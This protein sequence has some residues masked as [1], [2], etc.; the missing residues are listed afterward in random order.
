MIKI[1]IMKK[2]LLLI[3]IMM[4]LSFNLTDA[5]PPSSPMKLDLSFSNA[6]EL[7]ET[8]EITGKITYAGEIPMNINTLINIT[9]PDGFELISGRLIFEEELKPETT[10]KIAVKAVKTGDFTIE[11]IAR[12]PSKGLEYMGGRNFIYISVG[13][14]WSNIKNKPFL[15]PAPPCEEVYIDGEISHCTT[16]EPPNNSIF[17]N[18]PYIFAVLVLLL[19]LLIILLIFRKSLFKHGKK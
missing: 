7:G 10:F 13:K 2:K 16:S 11:G 6:P 5:T 17:D 9:L 8:A 19:A 1:K 15:K 18:L 4:L 12:T 3:L 14:Y